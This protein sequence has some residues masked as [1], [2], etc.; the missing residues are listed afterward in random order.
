MR[1]IVTI[2]EGHGEVEAVPVLLRRIARQVA[3]AAALDVPRPIRVKRN[4]LLREGELERAV[5]LAAAKA[6]AHGCILILLDANGDCPAQLAPIVL[7]RAVAARRD[8]DIRV[9]LAKMEY[10]AWFLAA[11]ASL[12][13][14]LGLDED[15]AP[16]PDPEAIRDAKGW[17]SGKM[18]PGQP[19]GRHSTKQRCPP[20][21]TW[22]QRG[23]H[24]RSTSCGETRAR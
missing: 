3:P 13:G 4:R 21:S 10:E 11:A 5:G 6:E 9:V 15:I 17:L 1:R 12:A 14:R 8:R 20:P 22:I 24:P 7:R 19:T 16:P 2:V 23:R 18:P